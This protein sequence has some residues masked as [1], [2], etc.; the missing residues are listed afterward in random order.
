MNSGTEKDEWD[1]ELFTPSPPPPV[2]GVPAVISHTSGDDPD[3]EDETLS[4]DDEDESESI[5][6][7]LDPVSGA[8]MLKKVGK[9]TARAKRSMADCETLVSGCDDETIALLLLAAAKEAIV[10]GIDPTISVAS[11]TKLPASGTPMANV[12]DVW[13]R[14]VARVDRS[15]RGGF[16]FDGSPIYGRAIIGRELSNVGVGEDGKAAPV[17][18]GRKDMRGTLWLAVGEKGASFTMNGTPVV[19]MRLIAMSNS[20]DSFEKLCDQVEAMLAGVDAKKVEDRRSTEQKLAALD[21]WE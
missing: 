12:N 19:G 15:K 14:V 5:E 1:E 13:G 7:K 3:P 2:A 20:S 6:T 17:V 21:E 4:G 8:L 18:F 10:R 9:R 11:A 16:R